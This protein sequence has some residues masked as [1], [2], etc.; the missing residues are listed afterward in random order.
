[1]KDYYELL[2]EKTPYEVN[3]RRNKKALELHERV[4]AITF[5]GPT[6]NGNMRTIDIAGQTA[7]FDLGWDYEN[8]EYTNEVLTV[9][10]PKGPID[11]VKLSPD[12]DLLDVLEMDYD[13]LWM[14]A[15]S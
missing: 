3:D 4:A 9:H 10:T 13:I 11:F 14:Q 15:F 12:S 8:V 2:D 5:L 7:Q 6:G 1:M